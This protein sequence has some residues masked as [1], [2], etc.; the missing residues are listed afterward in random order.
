MDTYFVCALV[1]HCSV[2]I[3]IQKFCLEVVG[4]P[5]ADKN[6][7]FR[8]QGT[9]TARVRYRNI[10]VI[11]H[12]PTVFWFY[13]IAAHCCAASVVR[14]ASCESALCSNISLLALSGIYC[15]QHGKSGIEVNEY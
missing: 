6:A 12:L 9:T 13:L 5:C 4:K 8:R 3:I 7:D 10:G 1:S 2:Y 14:M 15:S 11:V